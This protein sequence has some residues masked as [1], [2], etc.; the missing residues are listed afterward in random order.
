[1]RRLEP[2]FWIELFILFA[3]KGIL[4]WLGIEGS[5]DGDR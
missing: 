1:M 5:E 2:G 4:D 3:M